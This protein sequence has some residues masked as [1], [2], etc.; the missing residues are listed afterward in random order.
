M[1]KQ[2]TGNLNLNNTLKKVFV[3]LY[4]VFS[5]KCILC[6]HENHKKIKINAKQ[7]NTY[8]T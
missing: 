3:F 7:Y 4:F 1:L 2:K 8:S 5:N 6:E